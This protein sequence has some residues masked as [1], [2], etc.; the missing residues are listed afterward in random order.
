MDSVF[1]FLRTRPRLC[2]PHSLCQGRDSTTCCPLSLGRVGTACRPS[3]PR[4]GMTGPVIRGRAGRTPL[5]PTPIQRE[6]GSRNVSF[7]HISPANHPVSGSPLS[8][9]GHLLPLPTCHL[10]SVSP[11]GSAAFCSTEPLSLRASRGTATRPLALAH[12]PPRASASAPAPAPDTAPRSGVPGSDGRGSNRPPVP[13]SRQRGRLRCF[14]SR[15]SAG[16]G[17]SPCTVSP[18]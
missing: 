10:A 9:F 18:A 8:E 4:V 7:G 11:R 13:R 1:A 5:P 6:T 16:R 3:M 2:I 15:G 14:P 17:R 12:M